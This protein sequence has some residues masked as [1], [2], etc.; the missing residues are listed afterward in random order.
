MKIHI[1]MCLMSTRLMLRPM[2]RISTCLIMNLI[3]KL[4]YQWF[5]LPITKCSKKKFLLCQSAIM[6]QSLSQIRRNLKKKLVKRMKK[7]LPKRNQR[8]NNQRK[9]AKKKSHRRRNHD[10]EALKIRTLKLLNNLMLL[11]RELTSLVNTNLIKRTKSTR[12]DRKNMG[13]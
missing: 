13:K 7:K 5:Q 11:A 4:I 2:N 8:N 1:S 9:R 6:D 10:I 12:R 3:I